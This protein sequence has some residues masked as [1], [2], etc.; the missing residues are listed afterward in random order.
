MAE[1][2]YKEPLKTNQD[3]VD[4]RRKIEEIKERLSSEGYFNELWSKA[5]EKNDT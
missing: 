3:K 2:Y 5:D 1:R 4:T